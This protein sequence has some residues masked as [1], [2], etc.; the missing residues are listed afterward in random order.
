LE[1]LFDYTQSDQRHHCGSP[2]VGGAFRNP[3]IPRHLLITL[4]C[5][6]QRSDPILPMK[7]RDQVS[8]PWNTGER[9]FK[10]ILMSRT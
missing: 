9:P 2:N 6:I 4:F 8:D 1:S 5:G 10:N 3:Y 7:R